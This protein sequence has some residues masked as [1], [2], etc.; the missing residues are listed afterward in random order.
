MFDSP[1][2]RYLTDDAHP[3]EIRNSAWIR[4]GAMFLHP[5]ER[6][7][8]TRGSTVAM[9]ELVVCRGVLGSR[10]WIG[11]NS[12]HRSAVISCP[13]GPM[14]QARLSVS[15]GEGGVARTSF[16]KSQNVGLAHR[17]VLHVVMLSGGLTRIESPP[18]RN[19]YLSPSADY[20][21]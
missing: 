2:G 3:V 12:I 8:K 15:R 18:T 21:F 6:L 11:T 16:W 1:Q 14:V 19:Q 7:L 5:G 10:V 4:S 13:L 20:T 9:R 17:Y